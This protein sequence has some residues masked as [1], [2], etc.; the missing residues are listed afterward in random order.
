[1]LRP[2]RSG[3]P[4]LGPAAL[5]PLGR[6][7]RLE[8]QPPPGSPLHAAGL[9]R[10]DEIIAVSGTTVESVAALDRVLGR[11]APGA[12]TTLRVARRGERAEVTVSVTIGEDPSHELVPMERAGLE[13]T[14]GARRVRESWL[15]WRSTVR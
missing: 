4:S 8:S 10:G 2:R 11:L 13:L 7:L 5:Q 3:G 15:G 14:D 6:G 12:T 1:V 9:G